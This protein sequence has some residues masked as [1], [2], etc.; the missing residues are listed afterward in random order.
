MYQPE[1]VVPPAEVLE[2]VMR[3]MAALMG[4]LAE[5]G[6]LVFSNGFDQSVGARVVDREKSLGRRNV[7]PGPVQLGGFT[8]ADLPDEAAAVALA[9]RLAAI[10]GL[11]IEVRLFADRG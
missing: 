10:T 7:L 9:D 5:S 6:A 1:G 2:P 8:V 4:E 11:P 3:D